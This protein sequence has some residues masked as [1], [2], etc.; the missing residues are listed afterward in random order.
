MPATL[1]LWSRTANP[2]SREVRPFMERPQSAER[3]VLVLD[4]G[5]QYVQLIARRVRERHAFA[6]IVRHDITAER[7]RELDP[8]ALI[9]SGGVPTRQPGAVTARADRAPPGSDA[10]LV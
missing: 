2:V 3:P 7:A 5:S 6:K 10:A 4:F 8:L 9:F 1:A